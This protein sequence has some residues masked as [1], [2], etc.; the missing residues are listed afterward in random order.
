MNKSKSFPH[1]SEEKVSS[2]RKSTSL[3]D[4]CENSFIYEEEFEG[5]GRLGIKFGEVKGKIVV[6]SIEKGTVADESYD[7]KTQMILTHVNGISVVGKSYSYV[8]N[9][10]NSIWDNESK[11]HLSFKKQIFEELSRILNEND[12]L[13]YY[14]DL[15]DLGAQSL[16]DLDFV[17]LRDLKK[18][19]MNSREI[20]NFKRINPNI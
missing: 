20:E 16:S 8:R 3:S 10:V 14:D 1:I 17:E 18:M 13:R 2:L 4:V 12:L 6:K 5:D 7:L 11:V 19:R 9:M 15:V